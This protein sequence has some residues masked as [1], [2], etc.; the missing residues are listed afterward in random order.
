MHIVQ[1]LVILLVAAINRCITRLACNGVPQSHKSWFTVVLLCVDG[2][3]W[4]HKNKTKDPPL[5]FLK[6]VMQ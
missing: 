5:D 6:V 3:V 1:C 4:G 2:R